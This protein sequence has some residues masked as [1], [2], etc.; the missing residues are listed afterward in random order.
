VKHI[1]I[2][3]INLIVI[4]ML[5][6]SLKGNS[7]NA[8]NIMGTIN[9][10]GNDATGSSGTVTY[11][12]GQIFYTY[13]G[14]SV[15]NVAQGIQ[16]EE[17]SQTLATKGNAVEPKTEIFIFPNPTTDFVN[18]NMEGFESENGTRSYQLYDY[19]GRLLKQNT[20]NQA[21]TQINLSDLSSSIYILTVYNN[22]KVLKTFKILKK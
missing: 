16:H 21:E 12:I 3:I 19:Q 13:I 15:Y 5:F 2:K 20:I 1:N 18:I 14:Q 8:N 9:A 17:I 22:N 10:S 11:S 4:M 7:Q 6:F